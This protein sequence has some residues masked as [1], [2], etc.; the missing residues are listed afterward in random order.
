MVPQSSPKRILFLEIIVVVLCPVPQAYRVPKHYGTLRPRSIGMG[1]ADASGH[2]V[3]KEQWERFSRGLKGE[4]P[5]DTPKAAKGG[6]WGRVS[7]S[8]AEY[9]VWGT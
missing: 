2:F 1:A 6:Q 4:V 5:I 9:R 7:S 8:P 3:K